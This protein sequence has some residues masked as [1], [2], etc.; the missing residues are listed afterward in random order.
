[1]KNVSSVE[2]Q[3]TQRG[4]FIVLEG[5]EGAGKSTA[6]STIKRVLAPLVPELILTR[7][8]GGTPVGE[9][10]RDIL[11]SSSY[12]QQLNDQTELLLFYAA[13][14][15]LIQQIILPAL[16]RG[17]WVL[18]DRFELST[19]AYQGGGRQLDINFI[20]QLSSFCLQ[21]L[22]PDL[23]IFLDISPEIGLKRAVARGKIDRIEAE[24][25]AFFHRVHQVYHQHLASFSPVHIIDASKPLDDVQHLIKTVLH[26]YLDSSHHAY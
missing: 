6:I 13:R 8:P 15:Q 23:T 20:R 2:H 4:R 1:M 12:H 26:H 5:L 3:T 14:T 16:N 21:S 10:I 7:D 18:A 9:A 22:K 17:A 25:M 19:F 24:S 11:K